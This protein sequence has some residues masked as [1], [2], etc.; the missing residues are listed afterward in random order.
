MAVAAWLER[1]V[2]LYLGLK[3]IRKGSMFPRD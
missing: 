2:M 3:N 1:V